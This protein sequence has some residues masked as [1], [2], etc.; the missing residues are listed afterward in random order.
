[1]DNKKG[2]TILITV[3]VV[4][5][6]VLIAVSF[7]GVTFN[8]LRLSTK[9][10]DA[11]QAYYM[12]EAG[13]ARQVLRLKQGIMTTINEDF[14]GT[15]KSNGKIPHLT[16]SITQLP[17]N[18]YALPAYRITATGTCNNTTKVVK[19]VFAQVSFASNLICT[20]DS[21]VYVAKK[22][23]PTW[24]QG[25]YGSYYVTENVYAGVMHSNDSFYIAGCPTFKGPVANF[26]PALVYYNGGPPIDSPIFEQTVTLGVPKLIM[27]NF[28]NMLSN[29]QTAATNADP[30]QNW[31]L[32]G[33]STITLLSNGT[34]SVINQNK[35]GNL[36]AHLAP[37]PA[38]HAI[39]VHGGTAR[40][41]GVLSGQLTIACDNDIA[42]T[43]NIIY[44]VPPT[45]SSDT[46]PPVVTAN[47]SCT[48]MLGLV[49]SQSV[50]MAKPAAGNVNVNAYLVALGNSSFVTQGGDVGVKGNLYITG[51]LTA[52][53]ETALGSF[54]GTTI[55][56]G[57]RENYIYDSR[58][59]LTLNPPYFPAAVDAVG[60]QYRK[61][62]WTEE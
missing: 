19:A 18:T 21:L 62:S 52:N 56:S 16:T 3:S 36:D 41:S 46:T 32:T 4:L 17:A 5:V 25:W 28:T 9:N 23:F 1:M 8:E 26:M 33:D 10:H 31:Y 50:V 35:Y 13:I 38:G 22:Y 30:A 29:I 59:P 7:I 40:V 45:I 57:Y 47:P 12:T 61:I 24:T 11:M 39:Y 54:T 49:S 27:P 51:G 37:L 48:D 2:F 55:V 58:L 53:H 14:S 34:M 60:T 44:N 15:P 6:L 20:G 42:I 43:D